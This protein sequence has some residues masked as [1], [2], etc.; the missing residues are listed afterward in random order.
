VINISH[1]RSP[2]KPFSMPYRLIDI[3]TFDWRMCR[4]DVVLTVGMDAG[5]HF[6]TL[7]L[8]TWGGERHITLHGSRYARLGTQDPGIDLDK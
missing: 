1:F 6:A 2:E 7:L 4:N 5:K 3:R 8:L